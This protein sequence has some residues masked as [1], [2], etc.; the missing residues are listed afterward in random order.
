EDDDEIVAGHQQ[1]SLKCPLG[2]MRL[3]HPVRG[4]HCPHAQ[5]FDAN[6]F[7]EL[8]KKQATALCPVCD[9]VIGGL[10]ELIVDG[11]MMNVLKSATDDDEH[12]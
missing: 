6:T 4:N 12:I 1:V 10:T 8:N 2:Y 5:C 7:L 9:R 11:F 3:Q